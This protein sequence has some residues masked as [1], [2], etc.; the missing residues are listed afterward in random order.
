MLSGFALEIDIDVE[1]KMESLFYTRRTLL[2]D[3]L[4]GS[5]NFQCIKNSLSYRLLGRKF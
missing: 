2:S 4:T 1:I 3:V 5:Y